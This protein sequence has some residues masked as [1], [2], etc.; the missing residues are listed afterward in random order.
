MNTMQA[1]ADR[2][3]AVRGDRPLDLLIRNVRLVNV[4]TREIYPADIGISGAHIVF[5]G[6][7]AWSGPTPT[8]TLDAADK[9]AAPGLIDT[10]IHIESSMMS[11]R[12]FAAAVLPRGTT[13]VAIDP[14][15]I[16]N[17]LGL[18]GVAYMLN[19]TAELP[20]RVYVQAPS[21][22]PAVPQLETAGAAFTAR[23]IDAM[24]SW[25]RVIGLAEVMD[26]VGVIE[27]N[28]RMREI[29][30]VAHE[31]DAVI[32]GHCPGVRGRDLA[33]YLVGGP[34][35]DHESINHD[36]LLEKLRMG[37]VVEAKDSSFSD[38]ISTLAE[39]VQE[40]GTAPPNLVMCTD[41]IYPEDLLEQG[42]MD[43]GVRRAIAA[44]FDPVDAVRAA[45]LHGAQR[46]RQPELG[47]IAPGKRADLLLLDDLEQ[48]TV[49]EVFVDRTLVARAGRMLVSLPHEKFDIAQE[50]TVHLPSPPHPEDFILRARPGEDTARLN[51][52]AVAGDYTRAIETTTF[53]VKDGAVN[54]SAA[55]DV[56][57]VAIFQRH[58]QGSGRSLVPVKGVGL[59]RGAVA[60][61]VAH[62]SHNLL[63]IGQNADDMALAARTLAD[64]GG[65]ICSVEGG[66]VR[67]LLPLPIA[68][69]MSPEPLETVVSQMKRLNAAL[70]DQG[71]TAKQPIS[72]IIALALPVIPDY[73]I[74]DLGLVDV[75]AQ[76][77]LSIWPGSTESAD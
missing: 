27:Q 38:S 48:F 3:A 1:R 40:L 20:L 76:R 71:I 58:S 68:G 29:L 34:Q 28:E 22:V 17:V 26:Y 5:A 33:A 43:H 44:G 66:E 2:V 77:V 37:M 72:P 9:F 23:D 19:A 74:T 14:H 21:C 59:Q 55:D 31:H 75:N 36:E 41:D 67:A 51:I 65:G 47:A 18:R 11:P 30:D 53:A 8:E 42:H 73:G 56:A 35:S 61:T 6:P 60:T 57:L 62:D 7:G 70:R 4:Y 54:I 49:N 13:T 25:D 52:L 50:N 64:C 45:T 16:G 24:L 39:I 69:L 46:I 10:H 15:E 32:S 63:V 12:H